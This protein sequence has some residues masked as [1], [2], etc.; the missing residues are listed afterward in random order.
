MI[1]RKKRPLTPEIIQKI[2]L[3]LKLSQSSLNQYLRALNKNE[4]SAESKNKKIKQIN[5]LT[6]DVFNV[7][8]DWYHDAI[9]ELSRTKGFT[10]TPSYISKRL[11]ITPAEAQAAIERLERVELIEILPDGRF[12][13]LVGD[14][15]TTIDINYTNAALRS[16]QKQVLALSLKSLENVPKT[17]RDHTCVTLAINKK[18]LPEAKERMK[19]FRH[20]FMTYMQRDA[21]TYDEVYQLAVSFYPLTK[22][23]GER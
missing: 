22:T 14:S 12:K 17:E 6:I 23:L 3:S 19:T 18:D 21:S 7:V 10:G 9:L 2:G 4:F 1:L 13:E 11:G 20:E 5:Q 15:T 16:L 8:S